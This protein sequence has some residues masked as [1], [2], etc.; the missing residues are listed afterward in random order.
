MSRRSP[1]V[2]FD[3]KLLAFGGPTPEIGRMIKYLVWVILA[4]DREF[5]SRLTQISVSLKP[6]AEIVFADDFDAEAL[7]LAAFTTRF[8][9]CD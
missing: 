8:F 3:D 5:G 4:D 1:R 2:L 7:R 6:G 9:S